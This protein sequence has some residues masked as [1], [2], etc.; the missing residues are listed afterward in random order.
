M[1]VDPLTTE[2]LDL[3]VVTTQIVSAVLAGDLA[4]LP[5][6]LVAAAGW[7]TADTVNGFRVSA[8]AAVDPDGGARL[9]VLRA[10]GEVIGDLGWKGGPDGDGVVEIGYGFAAPSRG[11]GYGTEAVAAFSAWALGPGGAAVL[12]AEVLV[13][14]TASRRLLERV[15]FTL[16][17]VERDAVWYRLTG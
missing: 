7:P 16:D 17:R 3:P 4:G 13:H 15:G 5:D 14:N 9:A 11:Q 8:G 12:T 10:T 6:G 1:S 2:R